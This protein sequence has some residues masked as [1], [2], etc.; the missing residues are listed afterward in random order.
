[1]KPAAS[2]CSEMYSLLLVFLSIESTAAIS[3]LSKYS[4]SGLFK[5]SQVD[6][7]SSIETEDPPD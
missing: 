5:E 3:L 1:M 6:I 7:V 4:T 2:M